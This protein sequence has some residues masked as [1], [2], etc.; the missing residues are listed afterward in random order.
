M[1]QNKLY[2]IISTERLTKTTTG[3]VLQ[4]NPAHDIFRG[5]FPEQPVMPGVCQMQ[6]LTE[7]ASELIGR[8][9][10][11]KTASNI[12]FLAMLDPR[13]CGEV[14]LEVEVKSNTE[15]GVKIIGK[16]F[17]EEH[18]YLKFRGVFN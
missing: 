13:S 14:K 18:I 8:K 9:L 7:V 6:I 11:V 10:K 4:I 3:I 5:H 2:S 1:L 15:E 17:S 12:K 16:L